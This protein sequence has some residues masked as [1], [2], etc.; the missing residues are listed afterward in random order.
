M[1]ITL[2][3]HL[4]TEW[5]KKQLLQGKRDIPLLPLTETIQQEIQRNLVRLT[6]TTPPSIILASTLKRTQQTANYYGFQPTIDGLLDELDF[7]PFEGKTKRE[8][9]EETGE[10]WFINPKAT[11]LREQIED[12]ER[13]IHLFLEKY[14]N[15]EHVLIF[16]HGAW[17]R[18]LISYINM[19]DVTE[20]NRITVL[21]NQFIQI[22]YG[23][24]RMAIE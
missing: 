13:R 1:L 4:P 16:G 6:E 11:L 14:K 2:I 21:N 7:G 20:M 15:C 19:G 10:T 24:R 9:I 17:I 18:G 22:N 5:N 23:K 3:R 12:L 8:L